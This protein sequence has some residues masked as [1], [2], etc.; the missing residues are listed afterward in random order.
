L[1][2]LPP[3]NDAPV[4]CPLVRALGHQPMSDCDDQRLSEHDRFDQRA[5]CGGA[6]VSDR[7]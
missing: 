6:V 2:A 5:E 7:K 1:V 3:L 4:Q